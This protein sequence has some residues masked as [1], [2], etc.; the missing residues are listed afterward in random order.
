MGN[1]NN[2]TSMFI[3][4]QVDHGKSAFT[5]SLIACDVIISQEKTEDTPYTDYR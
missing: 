4:S 5:D 1:Q 3:I 2:I